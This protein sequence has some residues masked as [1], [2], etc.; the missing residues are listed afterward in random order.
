MTTL[1]SP[2]GERKLSAGIY[3]QMQRAIVECSLPP[4]TPLSDSELASQFGV[5]RTPVRDTLH[6]LEASGL[7]ERHRSS[8]W[9]VTLIRLEDV[10]ELYELRAVLEPV[11]LPKLVDADEATVRGIA[12]MFDGLGPTLASE[13]A[14]LYLSRDDKFHSA[15][16]AAADNKRLSRAYEVVDRQL[17][18]CKRFVSYRD[19][20]RRN[21]SLAEH[22]AVCDAIGNR[23]LNAA[24]DALLAHLSAAQETLT[25]AVKVS[26]L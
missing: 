8:G 19:D 2:A 24:R 14:E 13:D 26:L 3:E 22:R 20:A 16:V 23:N 25:N 10:N 15:I 11:G 4:G 21:A 5:S 17:A 18:R 1:F 6:L 9:R 7:V 12:T